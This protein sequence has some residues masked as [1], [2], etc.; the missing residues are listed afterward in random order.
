[1]QSGYRCTVIGHNIFNPSLARNMLEGG[2]IVTPPLLKSHPLFAAF[3]IINLKTGGS[4]RR[5]RTRILR[6]HSPFRSSTDVTASGRKTTIED[7]PLSARIRGT[8]AGRTQLS[9]PPFS[10]EVLQT[11]FHNAGA[12]ATLRYKNIL[13]VDPGAAIAVSKRAQA[14]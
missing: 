6:T 5:D 9:V 4:L 2:K 3:F 12:V 8:F 11:N 10:T 7:I 1:M 14:R 13:L